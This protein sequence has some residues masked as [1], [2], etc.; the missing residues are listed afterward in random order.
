M[1]NIA[2]EMTHSVETA[3]SCDFAWNYWTNVA[4][5]DDPPAKFELNGPFAA[6]SKGTTILPGQEPLY[7][8]IR[9]VTAESSA[10]IEFAL[11]GASLLFEWSFAPLTEQRTRITQRVV[12][13]GEK[14][15][16]LVPQVGGTFDSSL[17]AGM[18]K[19]ATAISKSCAE[20]KNPQ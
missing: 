3:A 4:N 2:W 17:P 20:G 10:T 13:A 9:E 11:D 12:L 7:W 5:W 15:D 18:K 8:F 16:S 1:T 19:L 6:G 14:A